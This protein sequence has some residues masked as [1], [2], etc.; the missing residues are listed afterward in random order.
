[1]E[2]IS[3]TEAD[4]RDNRTTARQQETVMKCAGRLQKTCCDHVHVNILLKMSEGGLL[5][6]YFMFLPFKM[7]SFLRTSNILLQT[8]QC[9]IVANR[10]RF[11]SAGNDVI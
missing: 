10:Q 3:V 5:R 1:M 7:L 9:C 2:A 4:Q 11:T 6:V 8:L